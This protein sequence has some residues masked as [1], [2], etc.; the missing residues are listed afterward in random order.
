M[1]KKCAGCSKETEVAWFPGHSLHYCQKCVDI[2]REIIA[3]EARKEA[4]YYSWF[5]C[6]NCGSERIEIIKSSLNIFEECNT[7]QFR[8]HCNECRA[9][10]FINGLLPCRSF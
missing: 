10:S 8:T 1:I 4:V 7:V 9:D 6:G 3:R 5:T 2:E